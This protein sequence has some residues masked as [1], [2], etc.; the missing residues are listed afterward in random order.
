MS[1]FGFSGTNAH[2]IL[3]EAPQIERPAAEHERSLQLLTLSA[4]TPEALNELVHRYQ[5]HLAGNQETASLGDICFTANAGRAHFNH[6]LSL[7]AS[8]CEQASQKLSAIAAGEE[9]AGSWQSDA[10]DTHRTKIAF[11]FTGQGAQYKGMAREL[12]TTQPVF[13]K[14][15]D[16]CAD[17][18]SAHL[19]KPLIDILYSDSDSG[20]LDETINTQPALFALEYS[21]AVLWKSWG[22]EPSVVM[23]HSVGEYV[24]A[25]VAGVFSVEDGLKLIAARARLMHALPQDGAM[26]S[27]MA[28]E[29]RVIKAIA[30]YKETVS[31]AAINGPMSVVISGAKDSIQAIVTELEGEGIKTKPL[32]VSHAFH[33]PL[34]APMLTAF[35]EA[36]NGIDYASPA[37]TLISNVSGQIANDEVTQ[38]AYW[39]QHVREPVRFAKSMDVVAQQDCPILLELGP[40]PVLLGMGRQ[41]IADDVHYWLPSLREGRSDWEQILESLGELYVQGVDI[42]WQGF[43]KDYGRRRVVLPT[44]PWQRKRFWIDGVEDKSPE[45]IKHEQDSVITP[46]M[47]YLQEGDSEKLSEILEKNNNFTQ[48]EKNHL[49]HF[50]DG[51]VR[52]H[53]QHII[54]ESL[55]DSLYQVEWQLQPNLSIAEQQNLESEKQNCWLIFADQGGVG[56]LLA[57]ELEEQGYTTVLI[58]VGDVYRQNG[59]NRYM[60]NPGCADDFVHVFHEIQS[61]E[62]RLTRVVHLWGLDS[63]PADQMKLALLEE[64]QNTICVSAI[65][66]MHALVNQKKAE[67]PK[68]WLVTRNAMFVENGNVPQSLAQAPLLGLGKVIA[69]EHNELWGGMVDL[70]PETEV[71]EVQKLILEIT[72]PQSEDQV[73]LREKGKRYVSRLKKIENKNNNLVVLDQDATY[74]ITGGLGSLGL[75]VADWMVSKG[76]NHLALIGR[77]QASEQAQERIERIKSRGVNIRV[78]QANV[79]NE[80]EMKNVI[81]E[82][83]NQMPP[84]KGIIHAAGIIDDGVILK[85]TEERFKSVLSPKTLGAWNLHR[86][87]LDHPIDFFVLFSSIA[88]LFGSPGQGNYAAANSFLDALSQ[89]RNSINLPCV[90][91]NW[92]LWGDMGMASKLDDIQQARMESHGVQGLSSDQGL[93]LLEKCIVNADLKNVAAFNVEWSKLTKQFV[94][95][96]SILKGFI[97]EDSVSSVAKDNQ[98]SHKLDQL[99]VLQGAERDEFVLDYVRGKVASINKLNNNQIDSETNIIDLGMDSLMI[100]ELVNSIKKDL[101]LM[102]YPKEVYERP[103]VSVLASYVCVESEQTHGHNNNNQKTEQVE[104]KTNSLGKLVDIKPTLI[105]QRL[106]KKDR[107]PGI[108]FILSSPRS[109]STLLRVMM[110]GNPALFSPPELHLLQ[111]DTMGQWHAELNISHVEEGLQRTFMELKGINA[112][113]SKDLIANLVNKDVP[114][115]EV[116]SLLQE[117]SGPRLFVDKSPSYAMFPN[118]LERAEEIF[119][120]AKYI[121]LIRHPYSV[122]DSFVRM[123]MNKLIGVEDEDPYAVAEQ[124]WKQSNQRII[125]FSQQLPSDRFYQVQYENLVKE[126]EKVMSALSDFIGV[127]FDENVLQPYQEKRMAD[128][129]H[130]NSLPIGDP[131]FHTHNKIDAELADAWKNIQLPG[132]LSRETRKLAGK[133][134]YELALENKDD[135]TEEIA[136]S[137][138]KVIHEIFVTARG[139]EFCLCSWGNDKDPVVILLHGI[140][141]QGAVW[142]NVALL[143]VEK[144][145]HV[146]APDLRGHGRSSH[147]AAGDSYNLVDFVA[148]LEVIIDKITDEPVHL[149]GHSFGSVIAAL[150]SAARPSKVKSLALV[151]TILPSKNDDHDL[152]DK[153]SSQLDYLLASTQHSILPD[154]K[155]AVSKL[156]QVTTALS[157]EFAIKLAKRI[158]ESYKT[159]LRWRWDPMLSTRATIGANNISMDRK[160]YLSMLRKIQAPVSLI[161]GDTSHFNKHGDRDELE[162]AIPGT[163]QIVISGGHHLPIDAFD[164]LGKI[165]NEVYANVEKPQYTKE[166]G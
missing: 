17:I 6:R 67:E 85:Q 73:A 157:D 27:V 63:V 16:R 91:I 42:D 123:R 32:A 165:L 134:N 19:D 57:T 48:E 132:L 70:A 75:Q 164:D 21:L 102:I 113:E 122:I 149:V 116:Y 72:K 74:L 81:G 103:V 40:K 104:L 161:F 95:I 142:E 69:L 129:I 56:E 46:V 106:K 159:G 115:Y 105:T 60:L 148:D 87:S 154:L 140:L 29:H 127:P 135:S 35:E 71:G 151:E 20:E 14:A 145:F 11:L 160:S 49:P 99:L 62:H 143:L 86:L 88:S 126:P 84:L 30:P 118:I 36:A 33:S 109:G 131:N 98:E 83:R 92:G 125:D 121:H 54:D 37:M 3:E 112:Q 120:S 80:T 124:V 44:Y 78:L 117:L 15:L 68:V 147:V 90:S 9:V 10:K 97:S 100:M 26:V 79:S 150:Y 47:S 138:G 82:V 136:S 137:T 158:T 28:D 52:Q 144:G 156:R 12:Y 139:M 96:P 155:S 146:I 108:L 41:C 43:D 23:G 4:K 166:Y 76:A 93:L 50:I 130:K 101:Q 7:T 34:M 66:L 141:E 107:L 153:I 18:L 55:K 39:V 58:F 5:Q 61:S 25:C 2:V 64:S 45:K 89:Y 8:T 13:K 110:A 114:V 24:A 152:V 162:Q 94:N 22:I 77:R 53:K 51:L 1:S 65:Y 128:G 133:F 119:E 163:K 111:F 59:T 31:I 38:P